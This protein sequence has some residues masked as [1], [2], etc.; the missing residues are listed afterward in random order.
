MLRFE[1]NRLAALLLAGASLVLTSG[2]RAEDAKPGAAPES[3]GVIGEFGHDFASYLKNLVSYEPYQYAILAGATLALMPMDQHLVDMTNIN[4][5]DHIM[6]EGPQDHSVLKFSI[7][8][9]STRLN[10]SHIPLS[11]MPS[12]A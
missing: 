10:S 5:H 6:R 2:A 9:K 4:Q 8:R 11:R 7:D 3:R 12:S 1:A